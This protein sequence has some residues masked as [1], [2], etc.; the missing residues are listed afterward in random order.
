MAA[1]P[2]SKRAGGGGPRQ[3]ELCAVEPGFEDVAHGLHAAIGGERE[4]TRRLDA[5]RV[6]LVREAQQRLD[7]A[8]AREAALLEQRVDQARRWPFRP[9][10]L[11]GGTTPACA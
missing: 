11:C 1:A 4:G 5:S 8:Q 6:V 7:L 3:L 10:S 9:R 2:W